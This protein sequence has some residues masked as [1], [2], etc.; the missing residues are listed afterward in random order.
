[1]EQLPRILLGIG[2]ALSAMG[3]RADAADA[4]FRVLEKWQH[5]LKLF[6]K[7]NFCLLHLIAHRKVVE[8]TILIADELLAH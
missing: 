4:W 3:R 2:D 5:A 8:A 7:S 1:L 6:H